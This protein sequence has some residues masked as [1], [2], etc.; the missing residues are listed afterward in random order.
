M[1]ASCFF[2]EV[3]PTLIAHLLPK[4]RVIVAFPLTWPFGSL[5]G[6][7]LNSLDL[8]G[9]KCAIGEKVLWPCGTTELCRDRIR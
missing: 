6:T 9:I 5:S 2:Y 1:G 4:K 3:I 8:I 7:Q